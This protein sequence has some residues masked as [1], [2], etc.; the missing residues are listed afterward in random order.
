MPGVLSLIEQDAPCQ[1]WC[2]VVHRLKPVVMATGQ[3]V[4]LHVH[5]RERVGRVVV[6]VEGGRC[7][8]I[9]KVCA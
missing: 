4:G 7:A 3:Q 1:C 2:L 6:V 8:G 9:V 5:V